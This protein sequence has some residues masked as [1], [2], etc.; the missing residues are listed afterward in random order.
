MNPEEE[1]LSCSS[2]REEA[3]P[4]GDSDRS[5]PRTSLGHPHQGVSPGPVTAQELK[6]RDFTSPEARPLQDHC[7]VSSVSSGLDVPCWPAVCQ[8][9]LPACLQICLSADE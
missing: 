1:S 9:G 2:L 8:V 3:F 7:M 5:L 4:F 6:G